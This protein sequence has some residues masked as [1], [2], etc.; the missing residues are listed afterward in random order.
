MRIVSVAGFAIILASQFPECTGTVRHVPSPY[1]TIQRAIDAASH[2][3]TV[4]V[5]PGRYRENINFRGKRIVVASRYLLSHD[6]SLIDR[7]IIDGGSPASPDTAS[8]VIIANGED[9]TAVLEGFTVTGGT[10]TVWE[11]KHNH[12]WYRE[13]GG[14]L[15]ENASPTIRCNRIVH[16]SANDT[17]GVT[18]AGGGAIRSD[19]GV[20]RILGNV[21]AFNTG[22]YGAGIT[23]N[24]TGAIIRNNIIYA[25]SGGEDYGGSGIWAYA[26]FNAPILIENNPIVGN[27]SARYGGGVLAWSTAVEL[28][29]SIIRGNTAR[30]EPG[31]A[32]RDS[33]AVTVAYSDVEGGWI[34]EGNFDEPALFL[35]SSFV[36][37]QNSP[38][39]DAGDPAAPFRD[40]VSAGDSA[41]A[42]W[43]SRGGA[44]NDAGA[45][46]G[47]GRGTLDVSRNRP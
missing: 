46:G 18:S 11:D 20:P 37:A 14:I 26:T 17:S 29:N 31:I 45:F 23:L 28:R 34:G 3:D 24:Y 8:C 40:P 41:K 16:N 47:P 36:P 6:S 38:C 13:G 35:D 27:S 19:G 43:P 33:A 42:V 15:T 44:R 7:T 4:L 32:L 9:S 22:R 39:V 10:G 25:N 21:I 5:A 1:P 2:G 12:H 30:T